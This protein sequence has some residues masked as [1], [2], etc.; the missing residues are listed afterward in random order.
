MTINLKTGKIEAADQIIRATN[1]ILLPLNGRI[2][3]TISQLTY[4][5]E[6]ETLYI[7]AAI[8]QHEKILFETRQ[9]GSILLYPIVVPSTKQ[10][11]VMNIDV[12]LELEPVNPCPGTAD[13]IVIISSAKS[14]SRPAWRLR[15][16]WLDQ[17]MVY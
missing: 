12:E 2:T 1:T 7:W 5:G 9:S 10:P 16:M 11:T 3:V 14:L 13:G 4:R 6:G 17:F 8:S 15:A